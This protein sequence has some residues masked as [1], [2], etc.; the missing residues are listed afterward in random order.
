[1]KIHAQF[2]GEDGSL[3]YIRGRTYTL[4]LQGNFVR[5][6]NPDAPEY[7]CPYKSIT[8]F[9]RNWHVHWVENDD[10]GRAHLIP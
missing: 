3:G 6:D 2:I 4:I 1:M 7:P 5:P 8:A 10:F 9:L